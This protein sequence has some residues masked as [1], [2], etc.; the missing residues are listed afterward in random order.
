MKKI[1]TTLTLLLTVTSLANFA[2]ADS[3]ELK[4]VRA[5]VLFPELAGVYQGEVEGEIFKAF[6]TETK[7]GVGRIPLTFYNINKNGNS[8]EIMA[9]KSGAAP[10][11]FDEEEGCGHLV[12]YKNHCLRAIQIVDRGNNNYDFIEDKESVTLKKIK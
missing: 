6:I 9:Y 10:E 12:I 5:D 3:D 11:I 1:I 4:A 8:Y 7:Q 2:Y